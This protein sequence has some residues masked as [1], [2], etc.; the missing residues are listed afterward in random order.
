MPRKE[1]REKV[2][3]RARYTD[4]LTFPD[5]LYGVTV[6]SEVPRGRIR[7]IEFGPGIPW[8]EFT[9]VTARNIP[10]E[11][12]V[13]LIEHDQPLLADAVVNHPE[14]AIVLLAHPD[15]YLLEEARRAVR[16]Q[17]EPLPAIF[18]LE[19]SL[20]RKQVIWGVDN[21]F[22]TYDVHKGDVD[23]PSPAPIASSSK[24][25]TAPARK[26]NSTSSRTP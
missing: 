6:R 2:T 23:A 26:S 17:I 13:F 24:P 11:N 20:S 12:C 25:N 18:T 4:D 21:V 3:G 9:V 16:I 5:L 19:D 22:K 7:K 15:P 8:D 1:G 10:G 14:E